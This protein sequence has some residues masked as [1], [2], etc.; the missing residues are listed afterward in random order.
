MTEERKPLS[1]M[2]LTELVN[3]L[4]ELCSVWQFEGMNL[5]TGLFELEDDMLKTMRELARALGEGIR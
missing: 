5:S 3:R 2:T 4:R 1:E